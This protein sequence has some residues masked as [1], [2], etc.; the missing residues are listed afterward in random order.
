MTDAR[1]QVIAGLEAAI[2]DPH[3]PLQYSPLLMQA[4]KLLRAIA[5][6]EPTE[7]QIAEIRAALKPFAEFAEKAEAFVAARA[8]DGES[9][10]M[11][12]SDFRLADFKRADAALRS[13]PLQDHGWQYISV[14]P[15]QPVQVELFWGNAHGWAPDG[16]EVSMVIA[17]YRDE[18]RGL[19]YWDGKDWHHC[20]T[21][22]LV[23]E[24]SDTHDDELPTHWRPLPAAPAMVAEDGAGK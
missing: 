5:P 22:H 8:K 23:F 9:P 19:G 2:R 13:M 20:G 10:I 4:Q 14:P 18:R 17:P 7:G 3:C 21:G 24:F 12:S 16:T 15:L 1:E 6:P 11:P